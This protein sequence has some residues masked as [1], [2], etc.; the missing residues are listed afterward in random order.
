MVQEQSRIDIVGQV[1]DEL[2]SAFVD[3]DFVL[4]RCEMFVLLRAALPLPAFE[5]DLSGRDVE[6][7]SRGLYHQVEPIS[8]LPE[9]AVVR[10]FILGDVQVIFITL[11]DKRDLGNVSFVDSKAGDSLP[12]WPSSKVPGAL[13]QSTS[14]Q[15]GLLASLFGDTSEDRR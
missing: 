7:F 15:L 1:D 5:E 12:G 11:D 8:V 14:K 13:L 6:C 2:E 4:P 3:F 9:V 10:P